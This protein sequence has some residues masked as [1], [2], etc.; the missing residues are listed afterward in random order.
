MC[1]KH[2]QTKTLNLLTRVE[3]FLLKNR[4]RQR[5]TRLVHSVGSFPAAFDSASVSSWL[6]VSVP[7]AADWAVGLPPRAAASW[8]SRSAILWFSFSSRTFPSWASSSQCS[9]SCSNRAIFSRLCCTCRSPREREERRGADSEHVGKSVFG[10]RGG[11]V[12]LIIYTNFLLLEPYIYVLL[13]QA[14]TVGLNQGLNVLF[15]T[16]FGKRDSVKPL[17]LILM[18]TILQNSEVKR[19]HVL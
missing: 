11:T 5:L 4:S 17:I 10:K 16:K 18:S 7:A 3:L 8:A 15:W 1:K 2:I 12:Q 14:H 13:F 6:C 9:F 19:Q